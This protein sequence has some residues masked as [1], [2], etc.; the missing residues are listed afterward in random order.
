MSM[1]KLL[2]CL[3]VLAMVLGLASSAV[4]RRGTP[5]LTLLG[6]G[7]PDFDSMHHLRLPTP[8][9][10]KVFAKDRATFGRVRVAETI[11]VGR[12]MDEIGT[13]EELDDG[14]LR[15]RLRVSSAGAYFLSF[16][17]SHFRL[18]KGSE[19]HFVSVERNY[20]EGPFGASHNGP[21]GFGS[22][23]VPDDS[24]LIEVWVP[25]DAK[26]RPN[27]Q[28]ESVSWG[29]KNFRNILSVP[30]RDGREV[31]I[32]QKVR[33]FAYK[34]ACID[35]RCPA[36]EPYEAESRSVAEGYDGNFICSGSVL[37]STDD[38]C[39]EYHYLTANHCFSSGK[40]KRLTFYWNYKN[41]TCGANNAP[42]N[43]TTKGS[44]YLAG[45]NA[46]DFF[47][48]KLN[49]IPPENW[50]VSQSGFDA[51]GAV[52]QM[53]ATMGFPN[54]V[55]M[56]IAVTNSVLRD[57]V[58][59]EGWGDDHWR[60]DSWDVG[61]TDSGSSGGGLFDQNNRV[62]GQLH[63]GTGACDSGW[64]EYGKLSFSWGVGASEHLDP[65][66][67]GQ[68]T[69]NLLNCFTGEPPPPPP[70]CELGGTGDPCSS[71]ADCCSDNC[72]TKGKW[73]NTCGA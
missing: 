55:P 39:T 24:A 49:E 71:N 19:M 33:Q 57:G 66:N 18:P 30:Y 69:T 72:K 28:I 7:T 10:D 11:P 9:L 65:G 53:G 59:Q 54:D 4:A 17:L 60:V 22:A 15:W 58:A 16:Q 20:Y 70:P 62:V 14:S 23:M 37:N 13:W 34:A 8:D 68:L 26:F 41:S 31:R 29:Y 42:L 6:G 46:S 35:Q 48:V 73:A 3:T 56:T 36:G 64:D 32:P 21:G 38:N 43:D 25:A 52:P 45:G 40:A 1:K 51:T 12:T 63:G 47:L 44:T 5:P 50:Y 27:F 61:G 2:I 67:T